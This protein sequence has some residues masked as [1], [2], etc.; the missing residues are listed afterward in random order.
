MIQKGP[1]EHIFQGPILSSA[2]FPS[3]LVAK[4][5]SKDGESIDL[6]LYNGNE[7]G[8]FPLE[9]S[10]VKS[11]TVYTLDG[12]VGKGD[13]DGVVRFDVSVDGRTELRLEVLR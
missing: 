4:A 6:V 13:G 5:Y 9:F 3:V 1:P 12:Q 8:T 7:S 11:G 2:P 10:R